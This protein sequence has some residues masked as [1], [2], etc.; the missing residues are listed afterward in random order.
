MK[1]RFT[2]GPNRGRDEL[3]GM[4]KEAVM[5]WFKALP[6]GSQGRIE[7]KHENLASLSD[8]PAETRTGY[9]QNRIQLQL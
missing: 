5:S 8:A 1:Y 7:E 6:Q 3:E 9:L 4:R 2:V